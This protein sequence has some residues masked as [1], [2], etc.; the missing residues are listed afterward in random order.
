MALVLFDLNGTLL[1]P[2]DRLPVLQRAV[3][4]A[5]AH[6]LAGD[7]WPFGSLLEAAGGETPAEMPAFADVAP[8]LERL[9]GDGHR[10][11]VI[12][13][14]ERSTGEQHL[15]RA[16][17]LGGEDAWLV[18]AHD[19]DLGRTARRGVAH[20]VRGSR[21]ARTHDDRARSAGDKAD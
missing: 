21:T 13:N 20:G 12:T 16:G 10:L 5:M 19:W 11:A 18:A 6:T 8:A 4:L 9:N 15:R 14:S 17:Q 2:G 3:Q 1:D 7:F